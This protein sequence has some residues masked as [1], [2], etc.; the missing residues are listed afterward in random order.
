MV[1]DIA[2]CAEVVEDKAVVVKAGDVNSL[3][4]TLQK[5]C[6]DETL[7][8]EYKSFSKDF[9]LKKY[10]WDDVVEKTLALYEK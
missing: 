1:S 7:V 6:D 8:N 9:I 4:Q 3:T 10:N 2:E 5:L